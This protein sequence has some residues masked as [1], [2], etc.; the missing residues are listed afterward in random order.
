MLLSLCVNVAYVSVTVCNV[1]A[2]KCYHCYGI[3]VTVTVC[4]A[5]YVV[6]PFLVKGTW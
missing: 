6:P 3:N 2:S 5:A 1:A 4:N